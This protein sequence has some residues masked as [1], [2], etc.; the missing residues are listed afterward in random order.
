MNVTFEV[1]GEPVGKG[2]ARSG[3]TKQGRV[4]HFTPDKTVKY[5]STVALFAAQAMGG[6]PLMLGPLGM[7][8][9]MYLSIPASWSK[10]K[11]EA[12]EAGMVLPTRKPDTSNVTK[13]VEDALNGVVYKDDVQIV[14]SR[15]YKE[16]AKRNEQP[17]VEVRVYELEGKSGC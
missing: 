1:P 2:R 13:A 17:R 16:F 12:A 6:R 7:E 8:V 4:V 11:A 10:K 5:E 9:V 3:R 15:V 14:W